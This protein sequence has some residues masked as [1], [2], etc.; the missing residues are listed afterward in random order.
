MSTRNRVD[1]AMLVHVCHCVTATR[2]P[3]C[4]CLK[5][6]PWHRLEGD[7][8]SWSSKTFGTFSGVSIVILKC[9]WDDLQYSDVD[10]LYREFV[11][12][13]LQPRSSRAN[14]A[15][16]D[17]LEF[18]DCV[19]SQGA[20]GILISSKTEKNMHPRALPACTRKSID[21][22]LLSPLQR[23]RHTSEPSIRLAKSCGKRCKV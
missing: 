20:L 13:Y 4:S 15:M 2:V 3:A 17:L 5:T 9:G 8:K 22:S 1:E 10:T 21:A 12:R 16:E 7:K 23:I 11:L 6:H 18:L 14:V 19:V